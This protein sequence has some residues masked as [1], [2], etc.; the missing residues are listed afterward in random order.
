MRLSRIVPVVLLCSVPALA[1]NWPSW[2]G[3]DNQG[4]CPEK[5]VPLKWDAKENVRWKI[6]L[7]DEGNSTPV[8]WGDRVFLT[9]A[10]DKTTWPPKGGNGGPASDETRMLLCF[11]RADGKLLWDAKVAYK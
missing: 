11:N 4:H 7:P 2:R 9:Q 3:P 1:G 6:D 10:K 8:V 5:D